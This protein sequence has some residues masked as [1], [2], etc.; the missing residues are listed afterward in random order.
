MTDDN[1]FLRE[2]CPLQNWSRLEGC[3]QPNGFLRESCPPQIGSRLEGCPQPNSVLSALPR[4]PLAALAPTAPNPDDDDFITDY[5]FAAAPTPPPPVRLSNPRTGF[6]RNSS[7]THRAINRQLADVALVDVR[8]AN[9][10]PDPLL[11]AV[12]PPP[13][14]ITISGTRKRKGSGRPRTHSPRFP[15]RQYRT[16]RW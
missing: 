15:T 10:F 3:P 1:V 5:P 12:I 8:P 14:P 4:L 2:D 11:G 9:P 7:A 6:L 16:H 13:P